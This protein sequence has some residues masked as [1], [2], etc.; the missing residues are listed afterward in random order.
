MARKNK[1]LLSEGQV[2]Q[3]MKLANLGA[4]T[5]GFVHGLP[6]GREEREDARDRSQARRNRMQTR[7]D[8]DWENQTVASIDDDPYDDA[9]TA[10]SKAI[11]WDDSERV[12]AGGKASSGPPPD[13]GTERLASTDD[14]RYEAGNIR[15]REE[16]IGQAGYERAKKVKAPPPES[17]SSRR[18]AAEKK[19]AAAGD[20]TARRNP[21]RQQ[22]QESHG[23]GRDEGSGGYGHPDP[24]QRLAGSSLREQDEDL[25]LDVELDDLED[26]DLDLEDE[27]F[28]LEDE[29]LDADLEGGRQV[30]VDDF[31]VALE[32]A[33]EDVMGEEVEVSQDEEDL[34]LEDDELDLEGD[35]LDLEA[36]EEDLDLELQERRHG[37]AQTMEALVGR[38]TR[39]VAERLV[40]EKLTRRR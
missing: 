35:E 32:T 27:D 25:E 38:I 7:R 19:A 4:L 39:R 22:Q 23:R 34:D 1:K 11:D 37:N 3:F 33:L 26:E 18:A 36:E 31:L 40:R 10:A 6:E 17:A 21:K 13:P 30:S 5:P 14:P 15:A 9:D 12:A 16:K 29:E 8:R 2:T 20:P 28:G 24:R